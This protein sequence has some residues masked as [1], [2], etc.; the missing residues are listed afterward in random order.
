M[1]S[2]AICMWFVCR[3]FELIQNRGR[4][5][6][7]K[8]QFFLCYP[9][10]TSPIQKHHST[11]NISNGLTPSP[12]PLRFLIS[13]NLVH[14]HQLI[15]IHQSSSLIW[16][17]WVHDASNNAPLQRQRDIPALPTQLPTLSALNKLLNFMFAMCWP[18]SWIL[19]FLVK[20]MF[21]I[22]HFGNGSNQI[23]REAVLWLPL[24]IYHWRDKM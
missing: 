15:Y 17:V 2:S 20:M 22:M 11:F 9:N 23:S 13:F 1:L 18:T 6:Q 12:C 8:Q 14:H 19:C 7:G 10:P 24:K 3:Y 5:P 21:S 4:K 16:W